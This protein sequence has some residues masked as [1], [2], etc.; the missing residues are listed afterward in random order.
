MQKKPSKE[1][2]F[3]CIRVLHE[4]AVRFNV[5]PRR[6]EFLE[7]LVMVESGGC[8]IQ[9]DG[10]NA[11]GIAQVIPKTWNGHA[12]R[13]GLHRTDDNIFG[14]GRKSLKEQSIFLIKST[15]YNE[16]LI[17]QRAGITHPDD[18]LL[19]LMHFAGEDVALKA[20]NLAKTPD[21]INTP[22]RN[23]MSQEAIKAN[24]YKDENNKGVRINLNDGGY[25]P[26]ED[27][28]VGDLI[29]WANGKM[30]LPPKYTTNSVPRYGHNKAGSQEVNGKS[31]LKGLALVGAVAAIGSIVFDMCF[32]DDTQ[33]QA[34]ATPMKPNPRGLV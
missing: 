34:Q 4:E 12:A 24:S 2:I 23:I 22:I 14:D 13:F 3:E 26:I 20:I 30:G 8:Q 31:A 17:R 21:G 5:E 1:E 16:S 29:N 28:K 32:G 19:Y 11:Y 6:F 10:S 18:G 9:A 25:I 7:K 33:V 15:A 27:F